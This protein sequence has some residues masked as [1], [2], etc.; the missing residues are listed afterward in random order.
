MP[1]PTADAA[2]RTPTSTYR[3]QLGPELT[4]AQAGALAG[5]LSDLGV[6]HA[7]LSPILGAT[8]GSAHGYDVT[9]HTIIDR[10]LGDAPGVGI[11]VDVVPNHMAIPVPEFLNQPLWS[12]LLEGENSPFAR[13]FDIEWDAEGGRI[14]LPVLDGPLDDNLAH[15]SVHKRSGVHELRYFDHRFPVVIGT[16]TLPMPELLE[17]QH[18][19]LADWRSAS[20]RIN[21]RR[22]CD[23]S[24]LIA[25]PVEDPDVFAASHAHPLQRVADGLIDGLRI[26]HPDGLA[27]PAGYL[28]DLAGATDSAWVVR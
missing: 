11:V 10:D 4:F 1:T 7:Y 2:R 21:Y 20:T 24:S 14:L 18:Y 12:V 5:Y 8:P 28:R 13:W 26:D 23:I 25:L 15:L 3:L 17:A 6:S 19:R 9:D 27:D 22:F 16:E